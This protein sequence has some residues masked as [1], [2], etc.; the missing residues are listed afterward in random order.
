[1]GPIHVHSGGEWLVC[2]IVHGDDRAAVPFAAMRQDALVAGIEQLEAA[3]AK[4]RALAPRGD[5]VLHPPQERA[6][7]APLRRHVDALVAELALSDDGADQ[8]IRLGG[9]EATILLGVPL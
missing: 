3:N 5:H 9:R 7:V 2:K 6:V 1:D 4:L 8:P